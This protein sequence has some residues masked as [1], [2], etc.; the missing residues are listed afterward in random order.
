MI[1]IVTCTN[2]YKDIKTIKNQLIIYHNAEKLSGSY[3]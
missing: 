2:Y 1:N 3:R